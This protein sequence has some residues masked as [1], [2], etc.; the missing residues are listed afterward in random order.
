MQILK[1]L[2][3]GPGGAA[4]D[5]MFK[6]KRRKGAW[7]GPDGEMEGNGPFP[8]GKGS[9]GDAAAVTSTRGGPDKGGARV[10][11]H[12]AAP[13]E[14]VGIGGM[15]LNYG[16]PLGYP[17]GGAGGGRGGYPMAGG[18]GGIPD[19][20]SFQHGGPGGPSI[21]PYPNYPQPPGGAPAGGFKGVGMGYGAPFSAAGMASNAAC[22]AAASQQ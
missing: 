20:A 15:P 4:G 19:F 6:E 22:G 21:P 10:G 8:G 18:F 9:N 14:A 1:K 2:L 12:D 16:Y 17:V 5:K 13:G 7:P 3:N 11:G